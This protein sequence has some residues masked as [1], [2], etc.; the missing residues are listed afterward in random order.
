MDGRYETV[1]INPPPKVASLRH[2][3]HGHL[4]SIRPETPKGE[5]VM[6]LALECLL[7][8]PGLNGINGVCH[9]RVYEQPGWRL[10][11]IAG[12]LADNPGTFIPNAVEQ[13][14]YTIHTEL[15]TDGQEFQLIQHRPPDEF[16]AVDFQHQRTSEDPAN[17]IH[18]QST[19]VIITPDQEWHEIPGPAKPGDFRDP[20]WTTIDAIDTLIGASIER[21]EPQE[22]TA[23]NIAGQAGQQL[24]DRVAARNQQVADELEDWLG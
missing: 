1:S 10:V 13:L 14:A 2:E 3:A 18:R 5:H 9:I 8:F 19:T 4:P 17:P 24:I 20:H 23:A 7:A 21:Y 6:Q 16:R 22:Y 11:V 15:L 12:E